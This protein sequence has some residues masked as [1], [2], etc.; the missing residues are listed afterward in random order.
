MSSLRLALVLVAPVALAACSPQR[1]DSA[2][3]AP[4]AAPAASATPAAV[5]TPTAPSNGKGVVADVNGSPILL[6][7]LDQRAAG[8][9]LR[10]RQEEYEVR[11]Q[12]L[13]EMIAERLVAAEAKKRGISAEELLRREVDAR[14]APVDQSRLDAIYEQNKPRFGTTP[15]DEAI[16]RIRQAMSDQAVNERRASFERELRGQAQV[17]V[18]LQ[19]PRA[20]VVI[21]KGAPATG[22]AGA[23][24]TI[25]EFTDYQC[26]YCHRAQSVIEEV[27]Q[28]YAGKVRLVHLDFPLD[29]HP[30]AVPA[31]RAARCAG[32]Q[33]KFWEMHDK[34]FAD[35]KNMNLETYKTYAKQLGMDVG[36]FEESIK[37][38]RHKAGIQADIAEAA[39]LG[40]SGTPAF[41]VNGRFL[42]G[43]KP[44]EA[45]AAVINAELRKKNLPVPPEA[46]SAG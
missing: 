35:Q 43:A 26:P 23:P 6:S 33:G 1:G 38:G 20:E 15:R 39:Q 41:F 14:V 12:V 22:A 27:L 25:V 19:V 10:L 29:G 37:S 44:F 24:V 32:E 4:S 3:A 9:L 17:A 21:P 7:E 11:S 45:F 8:R 30:E 42:S 18:Q 36:K 40:N 13:D 28:R 16:A 46:A 5:S 31:A 2:S 34:I